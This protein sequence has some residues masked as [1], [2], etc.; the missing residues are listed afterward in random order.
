MSVS[1]SASSSLTASIKSARKIYYMRKYISRQYYLPFSARN[2]GECQGCEG[3]D[4]CLICV[5]SYLAS[6]EAADLITS[7]LGKLEAHVRRIQ[8]W[9]SLSSNFFPQWLFY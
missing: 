4:D 6:W 2:G 5:I 9:T 7:E 1:Q 3:R 8:P